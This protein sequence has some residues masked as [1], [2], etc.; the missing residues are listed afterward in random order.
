MQRILRDL[1]TDALANGA[2]RPVGSALPAADVT[3]VCKSQLVRR[4]REYLSVALVRTLVAGLDSRTADARREA[5]DLEVLG[6]KDAPVY[7]VRL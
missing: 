2:Q 1:A 4:W 5:A 3:E 6:G 7:G